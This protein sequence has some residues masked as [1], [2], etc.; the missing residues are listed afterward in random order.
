[1]YEA[2]QAKKKSNK[3]HKDLCGAKWA[4]SR[5]GSIFIILKMLYRAFMNFLRHFL[6]NLIILSSKTNEIRKPFWSDFH[7]QPLQSMIISTFDFV[8]SL[9]TISIDINYFCFNVFMKVSVFFCNFSCNLN[10]IQCNFFN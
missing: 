10:S 9:F 5:R 8:P 2:Q 3:N 6:H 1:M 7:S 4:P